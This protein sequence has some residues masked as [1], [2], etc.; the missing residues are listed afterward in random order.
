MPLARSFF[1]TQLDPHASLEPFIPFLQESLLA[2]CRADQCPSAA[3]L[4]ELIADGA[5]ANYRGGAYGWPPLHWLAIRGHHDAIP[6]LVQLGAL[7]NT[8]DDSGISA[9]FLAAQNGHFMAFGA[10]KS[11]KADI[12]LA[13]A[14][15]VKTPVDALINYLRQGY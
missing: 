4:A 15:G 2:A 6:S 7:V 3:R 14:S 10:L 8:Q 1:R 11:L 13:T 9:V 5:D 12:G